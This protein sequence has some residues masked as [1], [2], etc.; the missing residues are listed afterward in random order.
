MSPCRRQPEPDSS[1]IS[2]TSRVCGSTMAI[3]VDHGIFI[4][5]ILRYD[6]HDIGRHRARPHARRQPLTPV[7]ADIDI[8]VRWG[9]IEPQPVRDL[10]ALV[11]IEAAEHL[12]HDGMLACADE[13]FI[14][15]DPAGE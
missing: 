6:P 7:H 14:N 13:N 3:I 12:R 5:A 2:T 9:S 4:I 8:L 11:I 10:S 15:I 1:M